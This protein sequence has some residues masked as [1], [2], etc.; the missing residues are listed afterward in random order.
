MGGEDGMKV[1]VKASSNLFFGHVNVILWR[2]EILTPRA[3]NLFLDYDSVAKEYQRVEQ[4]RSSSF[5]P[6]CDLLVYI[7]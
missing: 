2:A 4:D 3:F 1:T 6:F 5:F 7:L